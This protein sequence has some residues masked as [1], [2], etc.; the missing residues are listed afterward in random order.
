MRVAAVKGS[1]LL[2]RLDSLC[3]FPPS[4]DEAVKADDPD[5]GKRQVMRRHAV[6]HCNEHG[7]DQYR[8]RLV[9]QVHAGAPTP[10]FIMAAIDGAESI[11]CCVAACCCRPS[12]IAW[13]ACGSLMNRTGIAL[14]SA[15]S[16]IISSKL[17]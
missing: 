9:N 10:C 4:E 6:E 14:I 2:S 12:R 15:N 7:C 11:N 13:M 3:Q 5:N 16:G 17:K 1:S 8:E